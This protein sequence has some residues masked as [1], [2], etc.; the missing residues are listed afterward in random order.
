MKK[1]SCIKESLPLV[2]G[3]FVVSLFTV[4]AFAL[5]SLVFKADFWVLDL[6]VALGVILGSAVTVFN[7]VFLIIS[8]NRAINNFL[9]LRGEREMSDEEA[10]KFA[11]ENSM[12]IQ[13]AIK[14]SFILRTLSMLAVLILAFLLGDLFNP[15]ATVIPLLAYR[16][17]LYVSELIRAKRAA[18]ALA[19]TAAMLGTLCCESDS[20]EGEANSDTSTEENNF[21]AGTRLTEITALAQ[22]NKK[23]GDD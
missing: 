9:L 14:S 4:G 19:P 16:P 6:G 22:E 7:Y 8:V 2:I 12:G 20:R 18:S 17:I 13:N 5:L 3:E 21:S 23:E 10:E 11:A 15:L 1:N